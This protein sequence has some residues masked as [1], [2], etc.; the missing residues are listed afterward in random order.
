MPTKEQKRFEVVLPEE[1]PSPVPE[2]G[3][4]VRAGEFFEGEVFF[5][6]LN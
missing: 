5:N 6:L 1:A 3:D 2:I 4:G